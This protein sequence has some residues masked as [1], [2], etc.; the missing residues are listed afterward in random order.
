[1]LHVLKHKQKNDNAENDETDCCISFKVHV[2]RTFLSGSVTFEE[3]Q[4]VTNLISNIQELQN[5]TMLIENHTE[6]L[7]NLPH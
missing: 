3:L 2:G 5:I 4:K 7:R 1:M 6:G